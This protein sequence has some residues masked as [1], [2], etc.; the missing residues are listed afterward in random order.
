MRN[1]AVMMAFVSFVGIVDVAVAEYT[2]EV[3]NSTKDTVTKLEVSED[4]K[5]WGEFDIGDG[6]APGKTAKLVWD[7]STE[8]Q[9]CKQKI[10]ATYADKSKTDVSEFDFCE[11]DLSLELK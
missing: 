8:D 6:I 5:K 2:F 9:E 4:G 1:T 11:E 7:E 10:K 3:I